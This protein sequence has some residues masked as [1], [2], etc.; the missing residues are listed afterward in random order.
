M[1]EAIHEAAR[2]AI[3]RQLGHAVIVVSLD[4]TRIRTAWTR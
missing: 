4:S 1:I 2:A 3:A